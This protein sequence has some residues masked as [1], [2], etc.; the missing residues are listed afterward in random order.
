MKIK[1][2]FL[3]KKNHIEYRMFFFYKQGILFT[4]KVLPT[5]LFQKH[6]CVVY[7]MWK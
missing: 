7:S 5:W 4:A 2:P 1:A 6:I 3:L